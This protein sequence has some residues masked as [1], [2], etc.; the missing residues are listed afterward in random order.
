MIFY[1]RTKEIEEM[2]LRVIIYL[3]LIRTIVAS[4][5]N[6]VAE[7]NGIPTSLCR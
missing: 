5:S 2:F 1:N 3:S 7:F 6:A 4:S